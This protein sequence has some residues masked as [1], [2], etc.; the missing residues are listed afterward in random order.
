MR[1]NGGAV[2]ANMQQYVTDS[3]GKRLV[4]SSFCPKKNKFEMKCQ[5]TCKSEMEC[6]VLV[7]LLTRCCKAQL[8]DSLVEANASILV[9]DAR[10]IN[11]YSHL[12]GNT[13]LNEVR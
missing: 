8:Y 1:Q 3:E 12:P 4:T 5:L 6:Q 11:V 10:Q 13:F 7:V 2:G 9:T